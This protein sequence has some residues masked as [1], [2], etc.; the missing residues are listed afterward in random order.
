MMLDCNTIKNTVT[1]RLLTIYENI[2]NL[3]TSKRKFYP[4]YETS[5]ISLATMNLLQQM[6]MTTTE[7]SK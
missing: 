1:L 3:V 4:H 2:L 6:C 5:V 7:G